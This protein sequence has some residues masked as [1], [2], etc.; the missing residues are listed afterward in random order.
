MIYILCRCGSCRFTSKQ[1]TG[2]ATG[3][4]WER[5]GRDG[6]P[7]RVRNAIVREAKPRIDTNGFKPCVLDTDTF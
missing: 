1:E 4:L 3:L 2:L 7:R 6:S 5:S